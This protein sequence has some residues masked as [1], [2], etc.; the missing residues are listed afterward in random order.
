M[1]HTSF[2]FFDSDTHFSATGLNTL[3]RGLEGTNKERQQFFL[4]NTGVHGRLERKW[5]DTPLAKVFTVE[6]SWSAL[7][8]KAASSYFFEALH[9]RSVTF[10]ETCG[11]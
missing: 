1:A 6:D 3:I 4:A 2:R 9:D 7:L 5:Q 10:W 8:F 11:H